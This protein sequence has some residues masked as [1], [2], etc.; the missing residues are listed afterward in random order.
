MR[1][2]VCDAWREKPFSKV[3]RALASR[4]GRRAVF[5]GDAATDLFEAGF[6][7]A[8]R[9]RGA[10]VLARPAEA[11]PPEALGVWESL[12]STGLPPRCS[13]NRHVWPGSNPATG[14]FKEHAAFPPARAHSGTSSESGDASAA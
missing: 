12:L 8:A 9:R 4:A 7:A 3:L 2:L 10:R 14:S 5:R 11:A 6:R 1:L 13:E